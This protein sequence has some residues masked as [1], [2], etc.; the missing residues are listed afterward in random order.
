MQRFK[1]AALLVLLLS[2]S[3]MVG[4][5][6]FV[7][8]KK[9]DTLEAKYHEQENLNKE[10]SASLESAKA[11]QADAQTAAQLAKQRADAAEA[12]AAQ[13]RD[14]MGQMQASAAA[15]AEP[16]GAQPAAAKPSKAAAKMVERP[17]NAMEFTVHGDMLTGGNKLSLTASGKKRVAEIAKALKGQY[18]GHT[19]RVVGYTDADPIQHSKWMDNWE[20]SAERAMVV[21]R[22][23]VAEGVPGKSIEVAGR[24]QY[25]PIADN[26]SP[27]GKAENR[28]IV[29]EVVG[30]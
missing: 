20:L 24:G 17:H 4:C 19:V 16:K 9:Y 8:R 6:A 22:E 26:K 11:G 12:Q 29:I 25:H 28:R 23:L 14:A 13:Y 3:G 15:P 30:K 5:N 10:L 21:V 1:L 7:D 18:A 2:T 27:K